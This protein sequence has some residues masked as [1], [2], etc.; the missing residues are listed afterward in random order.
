MADSLDGKERVLLDPNTLRADGTAALSG[1]GAEQGR[2]AARLWDRRR[3]ARTGCEWHVRDI[4]TGKDLADV[5][6]WSK[7]SGAAWTPDQRGLLLP[8]VRR[9]EAGRG[10]ARRE[11]TSP[12]LYLHRLGEPQSADKLIYERPDQKQWMFSPMVTEDG[13]YLVIVV[14]TTDVGKNLLF[15]QDLR[16][17]GAEDRRADPR[18]R[19]ALYAPLGNQGSVF[20]FRRPT[21]APRGRIVAIDLARPERENWR[22]I[23][24]QQDRSRSTARA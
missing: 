16:E 14:E 19:S 3:A 2:Q 4:A 22:E 23:V 17:R 20:Y 1:H 11:R 8:A 5:V 15:Y 9:A 18:T 10:A 21:D 24:P 7:F 13:R 6:R 12:K